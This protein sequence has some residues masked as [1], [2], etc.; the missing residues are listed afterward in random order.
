LRQADLWSL[1]MT[2]RKFIQKAVEIVLAIVAGTRF[3][4]RNVKPRKFVRA[5]KLRKFK[6]SIKPLQKI[7]S[8]GKWSG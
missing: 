4:A 6:G 1:E 8:Q 5:V 7:E 3:L 2:R